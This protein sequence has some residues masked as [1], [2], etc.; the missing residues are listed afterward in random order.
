MAIIIFGICIILFISGI[1]LW[2]LGFKSFKK[3]KTI[4]AIILIAFGVLLFIPPLY[5]VYRISP[6]IVKNNIRLSY[7]YAKE[8]SQ[9]N[10]GFNERYISSKKAVS[11]INLE[12]N[13]FINGKGDLSI[14]PKEETE[15]ITIKLEGNIEEKVK[16]M[17]WYVNECLIEFIPEN[18]FVDGKILIK[19]NMY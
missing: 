7:E 19:I 2:M 5:M 6:Y 8:F 13:G 11:G 1:V 12:I 16:N 17:D 15:R 14:R 18:E 3:R 9:I 10:H 4:S